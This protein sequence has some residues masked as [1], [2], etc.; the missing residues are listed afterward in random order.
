MRME[1]RRVLFRAGRGAWYVAIDPARDEVVGSCGVIVTE[2]RG[3]FQA[4]E[5]AAAHRRRGI[6]SRL[7]AE[8]GRDAGENHGAEQLVIVAEAGYHALGLYESLG[9]EPKERVCGVCLW[10]PA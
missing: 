5:T 4:V 7:V 9:F 8:A 10:P 3:R 1:D 6:A 2:G